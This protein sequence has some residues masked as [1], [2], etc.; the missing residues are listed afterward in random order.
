MGFVLAVTLVL[1]GCNSDSTIEKQLSITMTEMNNVEKE[2]RDAQG[3][4]TELEKLEQELFNETM[5]LTQ[6]QLDELKIKV[7]ELEE[8]LGQ[9]LAHI[10]GEEKSI[11]K[12]RKSAAKLDAIIEQADTN[13]KK[14]IEQLKIAVTSRYEL[15]SAF[16]VEYK[17]LAS[18]QKELYGM[19]FFEETELMALKDLVGEVNAQ[20]DVVQLAVTSFNDATVKMNV[21]IDD[22]IADLQK[23]Q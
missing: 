17:K 9:R 6:K 15:H 12:A 22:T 3:E 19:L 8:L 7:T 2:Y 18:L 1:S 16:V 13:A 20:K 23:E 14:S 21:L 4:L 11:S 10:E 5:E